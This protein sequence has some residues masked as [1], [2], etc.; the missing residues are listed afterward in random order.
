MPLIHFK[1]QNKHP[2][3][4]GGIQM[5]KKIRSYFDRKPT[6]SVLLH[7][8]FYVSTNMDEEFHFFKRVKLNK[9]SRH[10]C[11]KAIFNEVDKYQSSKAMCMMDL[12]SGP[13]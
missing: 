1:I 9:S 7:C 12:P 2:L 5:G 6:F 3:G 8:I 11:L 10:H 13:C 4:I